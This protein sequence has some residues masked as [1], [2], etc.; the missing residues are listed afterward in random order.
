V[1]PGISFLSSRPLDP[2]QPPAMIPPLNGPI[3]TLCTIIDVVVGSAA[4]AEIGAGYLNCQEVVP[5]VTTLKELG[6]PQSPTPL[7]VDNTTSNGFA[8]VTMKQKRSKAMDMRWY[9]LRE[10]RVR[11]GQILVYFRPGKDNLTEPFTKHHPPA[12][13]SD[14]K[15]KFV[16]TAASL[17]RR[18][19]RTLC[20]GVFFR[21]LI[22]V[23]PRVMRP[24]A[25][26]RPCK[27]TNSPQ[28]L[29]QPPMTGLSADNPFLSADKTGLSTDKT[30]SST[31]DKALE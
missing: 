10:D 24:R 23:R 20:E 25:P 4:E 3:H 16:H 1:P 13:I 22:S 2:H 18:Y 17:I 12:H 8:N 31:A 30:G 9:W 27:P 19:S 5:I 21:L 29:R 6:H 14:M 11:Q 26:T 28:K 15:P 7:Q